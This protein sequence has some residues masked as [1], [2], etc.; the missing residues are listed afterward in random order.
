MCVYSLHFQEWA[1]YALNF[2]AITVFRIS[3]E[4]RDFHHSEE[5]ASSAGEAPTACRRPP[6]MRI[7]DSCAPRPGTQTFTVRIFHTPSFRWVILRMPVFGVPHEVVEEKTAE[8]LEVV[9][10]KPSDL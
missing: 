8:D 10:W 1:R 5:V 4:H 3:T 9:T 2:Y 7:A 6:L